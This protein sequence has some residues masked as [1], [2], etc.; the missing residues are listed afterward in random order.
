M[1]VDIKKE[2]DVRYV[3]VIG[4]ENWVKDWGECVYERERKLSEGRLGL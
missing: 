4:R 3:F 1:Y 2:K